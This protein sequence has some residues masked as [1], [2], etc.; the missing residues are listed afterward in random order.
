MIPFSRDQFFG[1]FV[2]Y[3]EAIWPAQLVAIGLAVLTVSALWLHPQTKRVVI[4]GVLATL[5]AWTGIVYHLLFFAAINGAAIGFGALFVI[6]ALVLGAFALGRGTLVFDRMAPGRAWALLL[7]VYAIL[8]YPLLGILSGHPYP[9][10]PTFGVTPCPLVIF[11][12][13]M[14]LFLR[15][16]APWSL[17]IIPLLWS[18]IG[19][20]AAFIL[21]VPQDWLLLVSGPVV[22]S[23]LR[24]NEE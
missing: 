11:T 23:V 18:V 17:L 16:R 4:F 3:N 22:V 13:G 10:T 14:L 9:A 21:S 20:S 24:H 8:L 5:W 12:F 19:G 1:V 6:Q 7:I 15:G 2:T